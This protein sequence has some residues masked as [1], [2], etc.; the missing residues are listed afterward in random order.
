MAPFVPV[1]TH[2]T[3]Q[4]KMLHIHTVARYLVHPLEGQSQTTMDEICEESDKEEYL[5][6]VGDEI[7]SWM[8][9][10]NQKIGKEQQNR[11]G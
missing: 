4:S 5:G 9:E 7:P 2:P 3:R 6:G 1:E 8:C 11:K 10:L